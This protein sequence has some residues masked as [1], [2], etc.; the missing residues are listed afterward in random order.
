MN[1]AVFFGGESCEHDIS[2]ITGVQLI[3]N[4][5]EYL[6]NIIPVYI[7][8]NGD[9]YTGEMLKD[10]DMFSQKNFLQSKKIKKCGMCP[11]DKS[12]FV[13]KKNKLK[14]YIDIDCAIICL[15]GLR[16]EDGSIAGLLELN[17]I[18]YVSTS[19]MGSSICMDKGVF[20]CLCRAL[21]VETIDGFVVC[22]SEFLSDCES[23]EEKI[24]EL[25][26]PIILKPCRQGSSIGISV[27]KNK[28]NLKEMLKNSFIY[29]KKVLIEKFL[30]VDKEV[31]VALFEDKGKII[32]SNTE[33][34]KGNDLI[35][36]FDDKYLK[37]R[38][39]FE[40]IKRIV[41]ASIS[42]DCE[43]CIK[44]VA[45]KLYKELDLFGVVRFDFIISGEKVYINEVNT[46]PG[47]MANY[48]FDKKSCD[49]GCLID[50]MISNA[51]HRKKVNDECVR[52]IDTKVLE[53]KFDGLKK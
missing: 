34:P 10:I 47:S 52:F 39:G 30:H 3:N 33:E 22:E 36:S 13:Y 18:P 6:Y 26:Y 31:N 53:S 48:L 43:M 45:N 38:G 14:K 44:S 16:G 19:I 32:Y 17:K 40:T 27:V 12:L 1:V 51:V 2:V 42:D 23:V 5:N 46:I 25:G 8:K 11:S 4:C 9:W 24:E 20:K 28:E 49:Y 35:L 7:C 15:H 37:N 41:P 29:D 21:G 50:K